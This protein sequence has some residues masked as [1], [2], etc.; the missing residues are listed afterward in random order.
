MGKFF[1]FIGDLVTGVGLVFGAI[2]SFIVYG[3]FGYF[4]LWLTK[5]FAFLFMTYEWVTNEYVLYAIAY[6]FID[7]IAITEII[8]AG[9]FAVAGAIAVLRKN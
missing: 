2:I 5:S 8:F 6:V 9:T 4:I 3:L 1:G 7:K